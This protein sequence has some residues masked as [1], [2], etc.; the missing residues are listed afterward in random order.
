MKKEEEL[1]AERIAKEEEKK[2]PPEITPFNWSRL[3]ERRV[4]NPTAIPPVARAVNGRL[5]L[6]SSQP[7]ENE[8]SRNDQSQSLWNQIGNELQQMN[9]I[10]QREETSEASDET[11]RVPLGRTELEQIKEERRLEKKRKARGNSKQPTLNSE[12][13]NIEFLQKINKENSLLLN[14]TIESFNTKLNE[15]VQN[16]SIIVTLCEVVSKKRPLLYSLYAIPV[17]EGEPF[18]PNQVD[19]VRNTLFYYLKHC[20]SI[21]YYISSIIHLDKKIDNLFKLEED[22]ADQIYA[23]D[24][25]LGVNEVILTMYEYLDLKISKI[26][27]P[28]VTPGMEYMEYN[29]NIMKK[30]TEQISIL[31]DILESFNTSTIQHWKNN[32][33][34]RFKIN[35]DEA[36]EKYNMQTLFKP[37]PFKIGYK[38]VFSIIEEFKV[39]NKMTRGRSVNKPLELFSR[40]QASAHIESRSS[41]QVTQ[42]I[43]RLV[44]TFEDKK[45]DVEGYKEAAREKRSGVPFDQATSKSF[46]GLV[47]NNIET[48]YW[49]RRLLLTPEEQVKLG[50]SRE[51]FYD[52]SKDQPPSGSTRQEIREE[53][54]P[55]DSTR[56]PTPSIQPPLMPPTP[57]KRDAPTVTTTVPKR[58]SSFSLPKTT[59]SQPDMSDAVPPVPRLGSN[60]KSSRSIKL[61]SKNKQESVRSTSVGRS[62]PAPR[63]RRR[64]KPVSKNN[65]SLPNHPEFSILLPPNPPTLSE[66]SRTVKPNP[67]PQ[68][69]GQF[70]EE[71]KVAAAKATSAAETKAKV[72]AEAKAKAAAA[73]KAAAEAAAEAKAA[74][75]AKAAAETK[76]AAEAKVEAD[77]KAG[78]EANAAADTKAAAEA[79]VEADVKAATEVAAEAKAAADTKA[80]ESR[81]MV[82]K[83]DEKESE[84][85]MRVGLDRFRSRS[86]S[87]SERDSR[88]AADKKLT[89]NAVEL[90][91]ERSKSQERAR[92]AGDKIRSM[93]AS[94]GRGPERINPNFKGLGIPLGSHIPKPR[95][96]PKQVSSGTP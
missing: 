60:H 95:L 14:K 82:A 15:W 1:E 9:N 65:F 49:F 79:K 58:S 69:K 78:A 25:I 36:Q 53:P 4:L 7:R 80:A 8:P 23:Q 31:N 11:S 52:A 73:A 37:V 38:G 87:R 17:L 24:K 96:L 70:S 85:R 71:F 42:A 6:K 40:E 2:Q 76:A 20:L 45:R 43:P 22:N 74:A 61:N 59:I 51:N 63:N 50:F 29:Q 86:A 89:R 55:R 13:A 75:D 27:D 10:G 48:D 88:R 56:I 26:K 12:K 64:V 84:E 18:Y 47:D 72:A 28:S 93:S 81:R 94:R 90:S 5:F 67:R 19:S 92:L 54:P 35:S 91:Q 34:K 3:T 62:T 41:S 44:R 33:I 16:L 39:L 46:R 21:Q 30:L 32:I 57:E 68:V 66:A 83:A 77:A